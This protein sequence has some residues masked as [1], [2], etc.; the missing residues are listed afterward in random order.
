MTKNFKQ[1]NQTRDG[2]SACSCFLHRGLLL[3]K[4]LVDG[5]G[6]ATALYKRLQQYMPGSLSY[7]DEG[8]Y[9]Y[10]DISADRYPKGSLALNINTPM[11]WSK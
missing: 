10:Q 3:D 6:V 7:H 9:I 1:I 2:L 5:I 8:M 11:F 4:P